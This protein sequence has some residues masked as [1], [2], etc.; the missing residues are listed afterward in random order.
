MTFMLDY[1][2]AKKKVNLRH[3]YLLNLPRVSF[4]ALRVPVSRK[5]IASSETVLYFSLS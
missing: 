2:S 1:I 4:S 5:T 3:K